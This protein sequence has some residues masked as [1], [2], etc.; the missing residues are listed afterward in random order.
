MSLFTA[1]TNPMRQRYG[2]GALIAL[3]PF[4]VTTFFQIGFDFS[5][6]EISLLIST[7]VIAMRALSSGKGSI[8]INPWCLLSITFFILI[9]FSIFT[10]AFRREF[11]D[12]VG[13]YE[14]NYILRSATASGRFIFY[15]FGL[16]IVAQGIQ[17]IS[18]K[19]YWR[20]LSFSGVLPTIGLF[21]QYFIH[22][23]PMSLLAN[24]TSYAMENEWITFDGR[25]PIAFTAELTFYCYY[26]LFSLI[27]T[28]NS[29]STKSIAK[30]KGLLLSVILIYGILL[31]A[32]RM[33]VLAMLVILMI[34]TLKSYN[35]RKTVYILA[36][37]F[38]LGLIGTSN[39]IN[40]AGLQSYSNTFDRLSSLLSLSPSNL[41]VDGSTLARGSNV[42]AVWRVFLDHSL[43]VG[44]GYF[45]YPA[46]TEFMLDRDQNSYSL[47]IQLLAEFGLF[48]FLV[49]PAVYY[50]SI[51]HRIDHYERLTFLNIVI[52]AISGFPLHSP[53]TYLLLL[54]PR[55]NL[56]RIRKLHS[57]HNNYLPKS[58]VSPES[59]SPQR[60]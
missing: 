7:I 56:N 14:T 55:T 2:V 10:A 12:L 28:L 36:A 45:N 23:V 21:Y 40:Q 60:R 8:R 29:I 34:H 1:S 35:I 38:F 37:V 52:Y 53:I 27:G 22:D 9:L 5:F 54:Y 59:I 39:E 3:A 20:F 17:D 58:P 48:P 51:K 30:W 4:Q 6:F 18:T 50:I 57:I 44:V 11:G 43:V 41:D 15:T 19:D 42:L 26:T 16:F 13:N 47:I 25:H 49:L 31:A 33:G 46:Y 32:S 24:N